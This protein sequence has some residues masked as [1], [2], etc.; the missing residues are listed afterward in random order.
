[1]VLWLNPGDAHFKRQPG[2]DDFG[3]EGAGSPLEQ[4]VPHLSKSSRFCANYAKLTDVVR[5]TL[6]LDLGM[7]KAKFS[8]LSALPWCVRDEAKRQELRDKKRQALAKVRI[9]FPKKSESLIAS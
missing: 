9:P 1:L 8:E 3:L 2:G 5:K 6:V 4:T 7:A